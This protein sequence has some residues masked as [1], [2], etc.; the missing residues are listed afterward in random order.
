MAAA[1]AE[2][3]RFDEAVKAE[4]RAVE[5]ADQAGEKGRAAKLR[6]RLQLYES[7]QPFREP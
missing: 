5:S 2:A 4:Q 3:G 1:Y 6:Q 7:R